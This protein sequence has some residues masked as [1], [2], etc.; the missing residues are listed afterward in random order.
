[1]AF[2]AL[3]GIESAIPGYFILSIVIIFILATGK[4]RVICLIIH[5]A[6]AVACYY[7]SSRPPLSRF[8]V[9]LSGP[10][11]YFDHI[12]TFITVGLCIGTVIIF[13]HSVY[14]KERDKVDKARK[15][16][17]YRDKLLHVV[18]QAAEIL[19]S[20][21]SGDL[22]TT[23]HKAMELLGLGVDA[24]RMYIWKNQVIDGKF[25]YVRQYDWIRQ[26]G[27]RA[28]AL[29]VAAGYSYTESLPCWEGKFV[30]G[31][32]V[33]G[34]VRLLSKAEQ[35]ILGS[36]GM[37]SILVIPLFLQ[38]Q[39]WGF[40]SFD[41][42]H[43]ERSFSDD[44]VNI[45]RSGSLL[46][47]N[48]VLRSE[49]DAM[50]DI[51]LKQQELMAAVSQSFISRE[52]MEVIITTALRQIGEF[53]DVTRLLTAVA[54]NETGKS[55][56]VYNW[57]VSE[58]WRPLPAR[59]GLNDI[60]NTA[61]PRQIPET[62]YVPTI[63][64]SDIYSDYNGKYAI[65]GEAGLKSFIWAPIYVE[66]AFWG[67]LSIE[68]CIKKRAWSSSD[69]Q[70]V[71][72]VSSA[73]AGAISRDLMDKARTKAMETAVQ[74]SRAK[75]EF[76]SNMSHEMRT[77]MNAII[78]MTAI[79]KS[80][81]TLERKDYAFEK[82]EDASTH[83]LGVINDILDMSK[84]E[85]NK[86]EL[87]PD[88]FNFEK[89][90]QKIVG[91]VNFRINERNQ[92]FYITIDKMIP[93]TLIGDDQRLAQVIT[94]LLSNAVKFTPEQGTIRLN[95]NLVKEEDGLC[96][97]KIEVIDSGIGISKEQQSRLF[98]SFEQA[99]SSTTR[100]FG[101]TGLGLAISKRIVELM[102]GEIRIE[103]DIGKGAAFSFTARMR[104][105]DGE[106]KSLLAPGVNWNNIKV[107]VVDDEAEI[108]QYFA[109]VA[110]RFGFRCDTAASGDEALDK[111]DKGGGYDVYFIDWKMPGMDGIELSRR[112]R[113]K[114][115]GGSHSV[116][117]MISGVEWNVIEEKAKSA[118]VDKYLAKPLFPSAIADLIN[119][120]LGVD[121]KAIEE[122]KQENDTDN[123]EGY[124][125]LLAEDVEINREIVLALLEPTKLAIDCAE[126]G[127]IA[128]D[129]F[130]KNP[131]K[132]DMI[133]MDVQMPEMDGYEAT[134]RIRSLNIPQGA[135]V[136][137]VAM[138]ANVFKEDIEK[139][140][141][142]G[143]NDHIGK[144]L[145]F[146]DVLGKLRKYLLGEHDEAAV[147]K[148][149]K[150][151]DIR[152]WSHGIVWS[153]ELITGNHTIDSQHKQIFRLIN[154]LAEACMHGHGFEFIRDALDFL[155]SYTVRHFADEEELL[156]KC[157]FP[158]YREHKA[159]HEDFANTVSRLCDEFHESGVSAD[160]L[161][162]IYMVVAQWLVNHIKQ[163]DAKVAEF[164]RQ[165]ESSRQQ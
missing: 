101:G 135:S 5:I 96:T 34:P 86:L 104:R 125:L 165:S 35:D 118:G 137:I 149:T 146:D 147:I 15:A 159:L 130:E 151:G 33:N 59:T 122:T 64:C 54:D 113:E 40:V 37:K 14:R 106:R 162:R 148:Y 98:T 111:I 22:K 30:L 139:A 153:N 143:M 142:A 50:L 25:C 21:E 160:L 46:V 23:L 45:L 116:V 7:F 16:L 141:A 97:I 26:G 134:R 112:I 38:E 62:G 10:S 95:A 74:A 85:A 20:S 90:L 99:E 75:G 3:G 80:A 49:K 136:P 9:E 32:T 163:E 129:L 107:L 73:I 81:A 120:C 1:M 127:A 47:G 4:N 161:D 77:P 94:N 36:F 115:D 152:D 17:A 121:N 83:L 60:I 140:M 48:A 57:F 88:K 65:L 103:S 119:E 70:L 114:N 41:D 63:V 61:F 6:E 51:Q 43:S 154:N 108:R 109:D 8:V 56:P 158:E 87:S 53:L 100:K 92:S 69:F 132:Y 124:C 44:D 55:Y 2:F 110:Q 76:L 79:G 157:N 131:E 12:Q 123:F 155:A 144:P 164:I 11:R 82:I 105:G 89:M 68:D 72:T 91:V 31:Q 39:F 138:T 52:P 117:T 150:T 66:G 133:F 67:L 29:K 28:A 71:G 156:R 78:G 24:D 84:I 93:Q 18:N 19:L 42:C 128:V 102:G 145:D 13:Q 126:N 27:S 58:E